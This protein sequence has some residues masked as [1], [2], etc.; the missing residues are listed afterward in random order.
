MKYA[1]W[2]GIFIAGAIAGAVLQHKTKVLS[3]SEEKNLLAKA[4]VK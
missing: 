3:S 1:I 2:S 4:G